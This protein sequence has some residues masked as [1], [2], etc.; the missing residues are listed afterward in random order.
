MKN[1]PVKV[2][3][4]LV[5]PNGAHAYVWVTMPGPVTGAIV[6]L[7]ANVAPMTPVRRMSAFGEV[8]E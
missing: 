3:V 8:E 7:N 4:T 2:L 5:A 1:A 6:I